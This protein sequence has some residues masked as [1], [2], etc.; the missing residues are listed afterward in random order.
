MTGLGGSGSAMQQGG[1]G[2][3]TNGPG[4]YG[5]AVPHF[6]HGQMTLPGHTRA[7]L[8]PSKVPEGPRPGPGGRVE[9]QPS[10][11]RQQ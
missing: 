5:W 1:P 11:C 2:E 10:R 9:S 6:G 4:R 8:R 3:G 7:H